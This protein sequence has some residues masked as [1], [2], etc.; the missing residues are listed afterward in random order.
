ME[1]IFKKRAQITN[2]IHCFVSVIFYH[3][4]YKACM[5]QIF[6]A[7]QCGLAFSSTLIFWGVF[8]ICSKENYIPLLS[9]LSYYYHTVQL[10]LLKIINE[11]KPK[12]SIELKLRD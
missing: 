4:A 6:H 5:Y 2:K 12:F 10:F 3:V 7:F 9:M 11:L 8:S 1:P